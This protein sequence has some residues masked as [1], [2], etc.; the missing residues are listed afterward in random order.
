MKKFGIIFLGIIIIAGFGIGIYKYKQSKIIDYDFII[1]EEADIVQEV[2]VTGRV[3]PSESVELAFENGG[4]VSNIYVEVGDEIEVGKMLVELEN[5]EAKAQAKKAEAGLESVKA[6]LS[7][8]LASLDSEQARLAELKKGTRPEEIKLAETKVAS[9][10]TALIDATNN[11]ENVKNKADSALA[12]TEQEKDDSEINF[13]N[14]QAKADADL[15]GEY[16]EAVDILDDAYAKSDDALKNRMSGIFLPSSNQL[17]FTTGDSMAEYQAESKKSGII[18]NTLAE[19]SDLID[20]IDSA[21]YEFIN[22]ALSSVSEYLFDIRDF[23][24]LVDAALNS[25]TS[26]T[27]T[28]LTTYQTNIYTARTNMNTA[29]SSIN[30]QENDIAIQKQTNQNNI[31]TAQSTLNTDVASYTLQEATNTSNITSAEA[32]IN[33]AK[34][35]LANALDELSIK[36]AGSAPEQITAQEAVVRKAQANIT[37]QRANIKEAE[38]N[39]ENYQAQIEKATIRSPINGVITMQEAKVGEII[40][41]SAPVVSIISVSKF[42]IEA[43]VPE[44][45]AAKVGDKNIAKVTLDAYGDEVIFLAEVTKIDPAE[46]IIE[47]VPTYKTILRFLDDDERI[48]SG[49]TADVDVMTAKRNDAISVP[50]R[51]IM[52]RNGDKYVRVVRDEELVEVTITLGIR[53]ASGKVE[54]MSGL[55][56]GDKVVTS[57]RED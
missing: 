7:Q 20:G 42:E 10:Q 32:A 43:F 54:V 22:E 41:A 30:D 31:D 50:F 25:A 5:A 24:S 28:T 15:A 36:R 18:N 56:E 37:T 14:V 47:G 52:S 21:N 40:S 33:D 51:A 3:K 53:D 29:I 35:A 46:T 57:V 16:S 48:K 9:A 55:K 45:D 8:F 17:S 13:L 6:Q 23:L 27:G 44:V 19:F 39:L 11:L 38:A 26:L 4:K 1:V 49:M 12:K 34:N 2:N